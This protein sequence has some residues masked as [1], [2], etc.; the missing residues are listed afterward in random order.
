MSDYFVVKT[1]W[2]SPVISTLGRLRQENPKLEMGGGGYI[3]RTCLNKRLYIQF[4][5]KNKGELNIQ[6]QK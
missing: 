6:Y 3:V 4:I 5:G 1:L 2:L